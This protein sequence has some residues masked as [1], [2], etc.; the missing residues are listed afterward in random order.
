MS[1]DDEK[2]DIWITSSG[3]GKTLVDDKRNN[4]VSTQKEAGCSHLSQAITVNVPDK[5]R[6]ASRTP[7]PP[8]HSAPGRT[9]HLP[10]GIL[11]QNA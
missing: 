7:T 8:Q 5:E 10:S 11:V 4:A 3:L 2:Q 9:Q 6:L 1:E